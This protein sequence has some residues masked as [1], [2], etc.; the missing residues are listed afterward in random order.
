MGEV[1]NSDLFGWD[2]VCEVITWDNLASI[3]LTP[4]SLVQEFVPQMTLD[5]TGCCVLDGMKIL[6]GILKLV[7]FWWF[8]AVI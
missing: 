1:N 7:F 8:L 5:G 3:M 2:S 6:R 4:Y